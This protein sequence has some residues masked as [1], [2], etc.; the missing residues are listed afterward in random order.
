M[1][2]SRQQ[3]SV[4]GVILLV[5]V[6]APLHAQEESVRPGINDAYANPDVDSWVGRLEGEERAIYKYR[7]A[8]VAALGLEEGMEVADVGA[9][10]GFLTRLMAEAVGAGGKVY[11]VD[12]VPEFLDL[13]RTRAG[14][15]GLDQIETVLGDQRS[16]GLEEAS[17]DLALVCDAYHHFEYPRQSLQSLHAALRDEGRLV[18][19]DFERVE[20]V[21]PPFAISHIRAGKGTFSDEIKDA[22]FD[23]VAEIPLMVGEGQYFLV[24]RKRG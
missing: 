19:I 21:S 5:A 10:T 11:A 1:R 13:I 24:F 22:G 2:L 3:R 6:G 14:E 20:G 18:V 23:L 12:V 15:A 16:T 4:L 17:I 7:H 9:G 8:I